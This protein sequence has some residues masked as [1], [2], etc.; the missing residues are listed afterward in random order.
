MNGR[1]ASCPVSW[2]WHVQVPKGSWGG[3]SRCLNFLRG[4]AVWGYKTQ[5]GGGMLGRCRDPW[6]QLLA[7]PGRWAW[8]EGE[9]TKLWFPSPPLPT[10]TRNQMRSGSFSMALWTLCGLRAWTLS[11]MITK[12]WPSSTE[13]ASRCLSR[14]GGG[15]WRAP[16]A[17]LRVRAGAREKKFYR[18]KEEE[19]DTG[20]QG[21][22]RLKKKCLS[23]M[24]AEDNCIENCVPGCA[25]A[26]TKETALPLTYGG[27]TRPCAPGL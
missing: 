10:K 7:S 2:G 17:G 12:C 26:E 18:N 5:F 8:R 14:L 1:M 25:V 20:T 4:W 21:N 19:E 3:E 15:N 13:S 6:K 23:A 22:L 24:D 16:R 9:V 11:W 27:M